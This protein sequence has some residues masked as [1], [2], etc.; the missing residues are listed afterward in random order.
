MFITS[1]KDADRLAGFE[2][3]DDDDE[4]SR[5]ATARAD[6]LGAFDDEAALDGRD[7]V[8]G[9]GPADNAAAAAAVRTSCCCSNWFSGEVGSGGAIADDDMRWLDDG[10]EVATVEMALVDC[11]PD[12]ADDVDAVAVA[13]DD[14]EAADADASEGNAD[15]GAD[16]TAVSDAVSVNRDDARGTNV[17]SIGTDATA[18]FFFAAAA[19]AAVCAVLV[20]AAKSALVTSSSSSNA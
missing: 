13:D 16:T 12:N 3:G 8:S 2:A 19:A 20:A 1:V 5:E 10:R 6:P 14:A 15:M 9:S 18:A 11:A 7:E 17:C 4:R